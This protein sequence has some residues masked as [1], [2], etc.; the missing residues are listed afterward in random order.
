M[1]LEE[2][3]LI[4]RE[5]SALLATDR[6]V[7]LVD[8]VSDVVRHYLGQ[9]YDFNG[10]ESTTDE[11]VSRLSKVKLRGVSLGDVTALLADSDLVK[12]AKAV[13]DEAQ[14]DRMLEGALTIVRATTPRPDAIPSARPETADAPA[15]IVTHEGEVVLPITAH[16]IEEAERAIRSAVG[17]ALREVERDPS[18]EGTL[19]LVIGPSL[20]PDANAT[21]ALR[22]LHARLASELG[23]VTLPSGRKPRLVFEHRH[24]RRPRAGEPERSIARSI[25]D[26]QGVRVEGGAVEPATAPSIPSGPST[27]TDPPRVTSDERRPRFGRGALAASGGRARAVAGGPAFARH[28]GDRA[29]PGRRGLALAGRD[30]AERAREDRPDGGGGGTGRAHQAGGRRRSR[31]RG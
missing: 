16:G 9:R 29:A 13:P 21:D 4:R 30:W 7:E 17:A 6:Q 19:R 26:E 1:A 5:K 12:F 22:R 10:L 25:I 18:F 24:A 11:V 31:S 2:I 14:C 28:G 20:R 15:R 27:P 23:T 3:E 8:R